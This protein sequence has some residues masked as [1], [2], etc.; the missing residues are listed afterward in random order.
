MINSGATESFIDPAFDA[1]HQIL[2]TPLAHLRTVTVSDG[3]PFPSGDIRHTTMVVLNIFG[4][5][6]VIEF[7][8]MTL[9]G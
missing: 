8:V 9:G 5:V 4:N 2:L 6:E 1:A 3:G 7:F